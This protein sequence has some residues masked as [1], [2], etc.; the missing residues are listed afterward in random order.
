MTDNLSGVFKRVDSDS[1]WALQEVV[2]AYQEEPSISHAYGHYSVLTPWTIFRMSVPTKSC[3]L[4]RPHFK[5][6]AKKKMAD[7]CEEAGRVF[8]Q[9]HCSIVL[10][11]FALSIPDFA[12]YPWYSAVFAALFGHVRCFDEQDAMGN[13]QKACVLCRETWTLGA[14]LIFDKTRSLIISYFFLYMFSTPVQ[15]FN[16]GNFW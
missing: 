1:Y 5:W 11:L 16:S 2:G 7:C 13:S 10:Y 12:V 9:I 4:F 14:V 8:G 15:V 6:S 3:C